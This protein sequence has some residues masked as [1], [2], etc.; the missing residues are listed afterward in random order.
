MLAYPDN[1]IARITATNT[2]LKN[3]YAY[4]FSSIKEK[5]TASRIVLEVRDT[6]RLVYPDA[7]KVGEEAVRL[8]LR[9]NTYCYE[10]LV[11]PA[12]SKDFFSIMQQEL[13]RIFPQYI[14]SMEKRKK[15]GYF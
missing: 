8:W 1:T 6:T 7:D 4:A 2:A 9:S 5:I 14:A 3:L 10:L 12:I 13:S 11:P 15:Q